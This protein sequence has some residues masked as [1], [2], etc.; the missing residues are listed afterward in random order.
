[1][2]KT[3]V[4]VALMSAAACMETAV[5]STTAGAQAIATAEQFN[6]L[7]V[8]QTLE[9]QGNT[10]AYNPDGT[11]SGPWDGQGISGTW[12]FENGAVCREGRIGTS[13]DL[14][15]DCQIWSVNG[16]QATFTRDRG[17]GASATYNIL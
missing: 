9:F 2:R 1:M 6:T 11:I 13:R 7:V 4:F 5:E 8:G 16:A 15:R 14:E 17:A 10:L 3:L 12:E